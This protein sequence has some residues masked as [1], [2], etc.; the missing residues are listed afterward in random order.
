[1]IEAKITTEIYQQPSNYNNSY[2]GLFD[3]IRKIAYY[4]F[5]FI[6]N[7]LTTRTRSSS[8]KK[9]IKGDPET[10]LNF[11][12]GKSLT[13]KEA[14]DHQLDID[15]RR[16]NVS[17][18][19]IKVSSKQEFYN[20][21]SNQSEEF[22]TALALCTQQGFLARSFSELFIRTQ[23]TNDFPMQVEGSVVYNITKLP[24]SLYEIEASTKF[25]IINTECE[26]VELVGTA[27]ISERATINTAGKVNEYVY[28]FKLTEIL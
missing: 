5:E 7:I 28:E 20:Q 18:N 16:S 26:S 1:M 11:L 21:F 4:I 3:K 9:S 15:V 10:L 25:N 2:S 6:K 13:T 14:L 19:G 23:E 12:K 24:D 22:L 8:I 17:I 27:F